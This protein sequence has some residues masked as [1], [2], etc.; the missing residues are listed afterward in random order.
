MGQAIGI[1][2]ATGALMLLAACAGLA[3]PTPEPQ[4]PEARLNGLAERYVRMSLEIGQHEDGYVDAYYGPPE[5]AA[6]AEADPRSVEELIT[7]ADGLTADLEATPI[8]DGDPMLAQRRRFLLAHVSAARTRLGM[9]QGERPAFADEAEALFG[10]RPP[11]RPLASYEPVVAQVDAMLPGTGTLT[12]RIAAFRARFVVPPERLDAVMTAAIAEC[13]RRTAA[14]MTLPAGESFTLEYVEGRPWSAYNWYQGGASSLIQV[15]TALPF[16]IDRALDLGCHEGYP[17]HHV[18]NA[19][20]EQTFVRDR[21]WI[22]MSIY[23][24]FSPMSFVAEGTA[25]YGVDLAFPGE[26]K[27]R[28]EREV[29][30]PLAGLDPASAVELEQFLALTRQLSGAEYIVADDYLAGRIDRDTAV[31]RLMAYS[32]ST[33]ERAVQRTQFMDAYRSYIINYGLGRDTAAAWVARQGGD[34]W[35]A[36]QSLLASQTLPVDLLE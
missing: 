36:L 21:G 26:E 4:G 1:A 32:L 19:L 12:E 15:N 24:L 3:G 8:T 16:S 7:A 23:P 17:G 18:Y 13:R 34:P 5:W 20:L 35:E 25:N 6:E 30:Y 29:L 27:V 22:E 14:H 28:F 31:E 9:I 11:L 10:I 2:L 33:R